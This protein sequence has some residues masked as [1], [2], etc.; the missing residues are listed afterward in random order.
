MEILKVQVPLK[1]G[2]EPYLKLDLV[3]L[4]NEYSFDIFLG[5]IPM[6]ELGKIENM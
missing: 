2:P 1:D 5:K 3:F 6:N 4:G